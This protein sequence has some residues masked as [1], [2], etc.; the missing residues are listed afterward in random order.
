MADK[1]RYKTGQKAPASGTYKVDSLVHGE[2]ARD[3]L[4][5]KI[6]AGEQFPPSPTSHD[7]ATWVKA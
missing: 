6:E 4:D 7:A 3:E 2:K 1:E 5:I